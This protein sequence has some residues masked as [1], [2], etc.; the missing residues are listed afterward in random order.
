MSVLTEHDIEG[1]AAAAA[2]VVEVHRR[3]VDFLRPGQTLA[4]IDAFV[5]AT[6]DSMRAKSAFYGYRIRGHPPFPSHACL[7]VNDCIVH[8]THDMTAKPIE[9]G[10]VLSIDIGVK[11]QGWIG[12]AA[13]TYA[14]AAAD[15]VALALMRCGRESLRRGLEAMRPGRPL[16]DWAKAVQQHVE[17]ECRFH[18]VRGLGGHGYGRELHGPPFISNVVPSYPGEWPDAWKTFTPGML[19]AVEPMIALSSSETRSNGREW[20]I[21]TADRS[22]SVHYEADVLITAEGMRDLTAGMSD[23][24]DIVGR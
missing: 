2:R 21:F 18:L 5:G 9:P 11:Y 23:L 13:W 4:E 10:D 20:P 16:I 3:L 6:L 8:G 17:R 1:A 19:I 12:D 22:L 7:S 24:P 14:I 15:D